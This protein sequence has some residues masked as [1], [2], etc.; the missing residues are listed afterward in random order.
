[1]IYFQCFGLLPEVI[2]KP[3]RLLLLLAVLV[4]SGCSLMPSDPYIEPLDQPSPGQL[5]SSHLREGAQQQSL[6]DITTDQGLPEARA[7]SIVEDFERLVAESRVRVPPEVRE[8]SG[9]AKRHGRLWTHNDSGHSPTLYELSA[10]GDQISRRVRV[11]NA[12]NMDW[13][14]LAQDDTYLYIADCGN[15][16]GDRVWL[17]I[18]KVAWRDLDAQPGDG[19]VSAEKI[20]VRM[21][22]AEPRVIRHGHNNDC[23]ALTV[24]GDELWLFT[25]NWQDQHTRLYRIDKHKP[26][27]E[28]VSSGEFAVQGLITGADYDSVSGRLALIGYRLNLFDL[29]AFVWQVPVNSQ[30]P[31]W[32]YARYHSISPMGQWEA[33]LWHQDGLL[34][35]QEQSLFG[36]AKLA[37]LVLE[38]P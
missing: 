18:Y 12:Q 21:A 8:S 13:E 38:G 30:A 2:I 26:V 35:S 4:L 34:I 36:P 1:M 29:S 33:V 27:Q 7:P 19:M 28:L 10:S 3:R 15:N 31:V 14:D 22:D 11:S 17:D 25:K 6:P 9:L 32:Q 37:R 24:V 16:L 5:P 23:E 20:Q